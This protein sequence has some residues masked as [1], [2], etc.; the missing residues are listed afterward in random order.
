MG[1]SGGTGL[2]EGR[3]DSSPFEEVADT[4]WDGLGR[5]QTPLFGNVI[6]VQMEIDQR[7]HHKGRS[8]SLHGC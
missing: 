1:V 2:T 3:E 8:K 6:A 5:L 4:D 7:E